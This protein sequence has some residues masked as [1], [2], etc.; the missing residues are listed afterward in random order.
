[1]KHYSFLKTLSLACALICAQFAFAEPANLG[2]LTQE[3]KAYHDSGTYEKELTQTLV[4][5]QQFILE[6]AKANQKS[7]QP[8]KLAIVLDI[9]ETSLSNYNKMASHNF[10]GNKKIWHREIM[11]ADSPAIQPMLALYQQALK[12]GIAVFFVTGRREAE[13]APTIKNLEKAGYKGWSGLYL[14]PDN[15]D[16]ASIIPFKAGTR[17]SIAKSGYTIIASIGDQHSDLTGGS[18]EKTFKLPNPYYFLP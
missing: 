2:L 13:R 1:M 8:K 11:A 3:V 16:K 17:A 9:D 10:G 15:Y 12:H 5:A 18:A 14:K 6:K 4:L 7:P